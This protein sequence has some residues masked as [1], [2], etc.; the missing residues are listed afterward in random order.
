MR[1]NE[2]MDEEI[3]QSEPA[4]SAYDDSMLSSQTLSL[5]SQLDPKLSQML[6]GAWFAILGAR[7]VDSFSQA[8]NSARELM[9]KAPQFIPDTPVKQGSKKLND[10]VKTLH[11][12]WKIIRAADWS[13]DHPWQ[14]TNIDESLSGWLVQAET[15]FDDYSKSHQSRNKQIEI[16]IAALDKSGQNL[17]ENLMAARVKQWSNLREYFLAICHHG[18]DGKLDEFKA[19]LGELEAFLLDLI[20]PEPIPLLDE[21]DA[22]ISEGETP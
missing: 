16:T 20:H 5:R 15:F 2:D 19:K 11:E 7:H 6:Q 10:E 22:L 13:A 9:E 14:G 1:D 4:S 18:K 12:A 3:A 17:P 21:L 8:A